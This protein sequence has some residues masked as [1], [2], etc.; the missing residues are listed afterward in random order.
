MYEGMTERVLVIAAKH[1][2]RF[3]MRRFYRKWLATQFVSIARDSSGNCGMMEK[4]D[5]TIPSVTFSV[6]TAPAARF[7]CG[8]AQRWFGKQ[9]TARFVS[10]RKN[11]R[12]LWRAL[13][14]RDSTVPS[15][16][17]KASAVSWWV[18]SPRPPSRATHAT[19]VVDRRV[20]VAFRR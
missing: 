18:S 20:L 5:K 12:S 2:P 14:T 4:T 1:F 7:C 17:P 3:A 15:G 13:L 8:L 19:C 9:N 6:I 16:M 11:C 10:V